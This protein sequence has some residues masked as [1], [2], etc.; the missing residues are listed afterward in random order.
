MQ[1]YSSVKNLNEI[2]AVE[3]LLSRA[4]SQFENRLYNTG[5]GKSEGYYKYPYDLLSNPTLQSVMKIEIYDTGGGT[6]DTKRNQFQ[7]ITSSIVDN[8]TSSIG[9]G[10]KPQTQPTD[11]AGMVGAGAGA[12]LEGIGAIFNTAKQALVD[13]DLQGQGLGRDSYTEEQTGLSGLTAKILQ[14]IYLY[15]PT[16]LEVGYGLEYEDSSMAG[17]DNLK[18]AK[19]IAQGDQASARDIGKKLGLANLKVLDSLGDLVG[20]ESGTFSKFASAQQRQVTN[21]MALHTFKEVK[22]REFNFAYT[23]LPRNQE[24]M[25]TCHEIIGLL[26]YYAH[27]KRSAG[28]GRFLDYPAEFGISFLMADGT[29]NG[30]LPQILKCALKSISIKY[31]E[32]TTFTTFSQDAFGAAP[33][34]ITMSLTFSELEI[35]TRDRFGWQLG[36]DQSP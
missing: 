22:R 36:K 5:M 10:E 29:L 21:P 14:S 27:P 13:G 24:E 15:M 9:K 30:Y 6:L 25:Q 16:G 23:F 1:E 32:D 11:I 8:I 3:A 26:K 35:L 20:A 19:A 2:R 17:L 34:K 33:T 4:S 12:I 7:A 28:S 18:L 31:G